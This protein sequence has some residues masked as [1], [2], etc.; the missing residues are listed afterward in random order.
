[1]NVAAAPPQPASPVAD[2]S[3]PLAG[4]AGE[5]ATGFDAMLAL[6]AGMAAPAEGE[7]ASKDAAAPAVDAD[8]EAASTDPMLAVLAAMMAPPPPAPLADTV[9]A[10]TAPPPAALPVAGLQP[11]VPGAAFDTASLAEAAPGLD[12]AP[13]VDAK[14]AADALGALD[15]KAL[16]TAPDRVAE[17]PPPPVVLAAASAPA[18][19]VIT[20]PLAAPPAEPAKSEAPAKSATAPN[21]PAQP[22]AKP[23]SAPA[24]AEAVKTDTAEAVTAVATAGDQGAASGSGSGSNPAA[25]PAVA[26]EATAAPVVNTAASTA[27]DPVRVAETAAPLVEPPRIVRGSPETVAKL[28]ADILKKLD[29]RSTRFELALDPVGLGRVDVKIEI[30]A[31]GQISAALSFDNPQAAAELRGRAGDLRHALQQAGFDLPE[32]A[33]SFD[34]GNQAGGDG[35]GAQ[36]AWDAPDR[37]QGRGA[38]FAGRA[39]EAVLNGAESLASDLSTRL[40]A[41]RADGVDVR[42]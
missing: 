27:P 41:P 42:I 26:A 25:V 11:P 7:A 22:T 6:V 1:M 10:E 18:A 28:S 3:A 29:G 20:A 9:A 37:G 40:G 13:A 23:G 38:A 39:F 5:A 33:L 31:H 14:A 21:A 36:T 30:G 17:A 35:R 15:S 12:A 2:G 34:L 19:P 4:Q 32:N 16:P 8:A 24:P